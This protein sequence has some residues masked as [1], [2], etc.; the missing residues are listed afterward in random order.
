V[1]QQELL[2]PRVS[3]EPTGI[4]KQLL[5]EFG[6]AGALIGVKTDHVDDP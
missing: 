1:Q 5:E 6:E 4:V 3:R 2:L